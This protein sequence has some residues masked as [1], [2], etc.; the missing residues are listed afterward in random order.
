MERTYTQAE[1]EADKLNVFTRHGH[2]STSGSDT[3]LVYAPDHACRQ[4]GHHIE[5][6]RNAGLH[7]RSRAVGRCHRQRKHIAPGARLGHAGQVPAGHQLLRK[8]VHQLRG[9]ARGKAV[10][11]GRDD[12]KPAEDYDE[13]CIGLFPSGSSACHTR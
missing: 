6:G 7:G 8:A 11:A 4:R 5:R 13:A 9:C 3:I 2:T 12:C 1:K 10:L